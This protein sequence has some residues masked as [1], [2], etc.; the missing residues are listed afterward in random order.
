MSKK[1]EWQKK[2]RREFAATNGFSMAANYACGGKR[3]AVLNRDGFRCV[4]CGMTNEEHKAVFGRPI[5][6]DHKDKNRK[7]NSMDN[8]QTLCLPCHGRKDLIMR[9]RTSKIEP[10]REKIMD[11]RQSGRSCNSIAKELGVQC[12]MI[13]KWI[14]RWN[15][16]QL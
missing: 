9:L 4:A 12:S 13:C 2:K 10:H 5:T 3:N 1:L 8:L 6:V 7:N 16:G 15:K 14:R 11:M